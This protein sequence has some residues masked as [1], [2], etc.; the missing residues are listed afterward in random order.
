MKIFD[1]S[2]SLPALAVAL[3]AMPLVARAA[4]F[5]FA[6]E[7]LVLGVQAIGGS[8][9]SQNIFV[10][11]GNTVA[12][13][14]NPNQGVVA[15]IAADLSATYGDDWFTREDLYFG[16]FGNRSHFNVSL[17]PGTGNQEPGKTVYLS[18]ATMV[19]GTAPKRPAMGASALGNGCTPYVGMRGILTS[20]ALTA[21]ASGAAILDEAI[22]GNAAWENSWSSR[23]PTPGAAFTVFSP[24]LQNNFGKDAEVLVDVQ[25]MV[26]STTA[27]Y[28]TTVGVASNGA[29]RLFTATQSTPFQTWALTFPAL[30]TEAKRL[31]TADPDNDGLTNLIEFVLNGN[32]GL[33]DSAIAPTLNAAGSDLVFSFNRRDDSEAGSTLLFQYGSDLVGWTD[34]A[35]GATG[36]TVGS[37]A[38]VIGENAAAADAIGI[39]LPKSVAPSGK[40]FGRLKVSQP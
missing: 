15:N 39:T 28:I 34:V 26:P 6:D 16:V 11:L 4:P 36:G 32:P 38:I 24:G 35:I 14:N 37:A 30:D 23:N 10:R 29:I 17:D 13:K 25:R 33:S 20:G 19:A 40:L 31:P 3:V 21:T 12:I 18:S 5:Q 9:T 7:D 1:F 22:N 27:T 2:S 8:G